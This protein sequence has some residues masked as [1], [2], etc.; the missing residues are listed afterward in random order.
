MKKINLFMP[1]MEGGGVEKNLILIANYVSQHISNVSLITFDN[2]YNKYFNKRI[3]IINAFK[4][5]KKKSSK[6]FKYI[7]CLYLLLKE[8][9]INKNILVFTFQANIYGIIFSYF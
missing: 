3:K 6:Y 7:C 2:T 1:A 4:K 9:F 8:Y 5:S